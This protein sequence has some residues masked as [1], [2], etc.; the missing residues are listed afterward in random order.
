MWEPTTAKWV[1]AFVDSQRLYVPPSS[2]ETAQDT[3]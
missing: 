3:G 1:H 2:L